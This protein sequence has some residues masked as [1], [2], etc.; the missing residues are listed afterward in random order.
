[1]NITSNSQKQR[2]KAAVYRFRVY[3]SRWRVYVTR[4]TEPTEDPVRIDT[5]AREMIVNERC[6]GPMLIPSVVRSLGLA[7]THELQLHGFVFWR[8]SGMHI[9]LRPVCPANR[10]NP[11]VTRDAGE[12]TLLD[13]S[14]VGV[15]AAVKD[16]IHYAN[17]MMRTRDPIHSRPAMHAVLCQNVEDF[18]IPIRPA[19]RSLGWGTLPVVPVELERDNKRRW[20]CP[21][22]HEPF[23][24]LRCL[25]RHVKEHGDHRASDRIFNGGVVPVGKPNAKPFTVYF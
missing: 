19:E 5:D 13:P 23:T 17:E 10:W 14:A 8:G 21:H 20:L 6:P 4:F 3:H 12:L 1:M 15:P 2:R 16:A 9:R 22:C 11:C 24:Y 7:W 18:S 25:A